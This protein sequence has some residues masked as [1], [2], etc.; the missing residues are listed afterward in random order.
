MLSVK[1]P[2]TNDS[3]VC[4]ASASL[5]SIIGA[6]D[7]TSPYSIS[8]DSTAVSNG[9]HSITA[10]A[11]DT[12]GNTTTSSAVSVT[13]SNAVTVPSG[14]IA[15]YPGLELSADPLEPTPRDRPE[16]GRLF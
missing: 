13:T 6:A 3:V 7:T 5:R 11:T 14:L 2:G 10:V 9:G 4:R 8:W 15:A 12:D 16:Q 1:R